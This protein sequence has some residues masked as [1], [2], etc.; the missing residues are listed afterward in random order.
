VDM[1]ARTGQMYASQIEYVCDLL[2]GSVGCS[3]IFSIA[4]CYSCCGSW[5]FN[6]VVVVRMYVVF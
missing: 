5:K 4:L 3:L 1:L 6:W 2:E